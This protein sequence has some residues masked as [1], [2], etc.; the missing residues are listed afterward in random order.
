MNNA[1]LRAANIIAKLREINLI[2]VSPDSVKKINIKD[3]LRRTVQSL[4]NDL[5]KN[6]IS[7]FE[8]FDHELIE[9]ECNSI[10]LDQIILNILKNSIDHLKNLEG[11][12]RWIRIHTIVDDQKIKIIIEDSGSIENDIIQ[13]IF[14]PFF[15]TKDIGEGQG[16]GLGHALQIAHIY[17]G[18]LYIDTKS[19]NTKFVLELP[20]HISIIDK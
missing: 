12:G 3:E 8:S 20:V 11:Q 17:Q 6:N 5:L 14:N 2:N 10:H 15:T 13:K 1:V 7:V 9:F 4:K 19:V 16:L 18:D